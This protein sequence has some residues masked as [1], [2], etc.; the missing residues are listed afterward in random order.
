LLANHSSFE[1]N[2]LRG[3]FKASIR[4]IETSIESLGLK[5]RV[6]TDIKGTV[7]QSGAF[8]VVASTVTSLTAL[9]A[10][11]A[12]GVGTVL[13]HIATYDPDYEIVKDYLNRKLTVR[14]KKAD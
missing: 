8:G 12:I 14:Y 4:Y 2:G 1:V 10:G 6:V 9:G 11:L 13:H 7:I 3:Q 5:C